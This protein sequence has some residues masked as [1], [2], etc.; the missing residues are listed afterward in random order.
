MRSTIIRVPFLLMRS[1]IIRVPFLFMRST[2]IRVPFLLMRSTIIRVPFLLMRST[3]I[4][5]PFLLM[6]SFHE[7]V[8]PYTVT[9]QHQG[10]YRLNCV[11]QNCKPVFNIVCS[12]VLET[13]LYL[14][15]DCICIARIYVWA[16][17]SKKQG[18][19]FV[20]IVSACSIEL[21]VF[22]KSHVYWTVHHIGSWIKID[23]LDVTC[24]II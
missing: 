10:F 15:A 11:C 23:Q 2:I 6:R 7:A 22:Y 16:N 17:L 13:A 14:R 3:I 18:N 21:N 4:R 8:Q 9:Q 5:V 24:F 1:T 19:A 20:K 12:V